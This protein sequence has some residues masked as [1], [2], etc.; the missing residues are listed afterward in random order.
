MVTLINISMKFYKGVVV[1]I[2]DDTKTGIIKCRVNGLYNS[3][4]IGSIPDDK[5]PKLYPL[6]SPNLNNFDTPKVGEEVYVVLDRDDKHAGFWIG[7]YSLSDE[8][9]TKIR[10]DYEGFKSI[11]FDEEE[12]LRCFFSRKEGLVLE[13]D[14]ARIIIK[15]NEAKVE[16]PDRKLHILDGMISLGQLKKSNEPAVLGDKNLDALNEICDRMDAMI[17]KLIEYG[18]TQTSV[19]S[20]VGILAFLAPALTKLASDMGAIK[21]QVAQT[22]T[23]TN[24]KTKSTKTSLD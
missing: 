3:N 19:V 10:D 23:V 17:D 6:Y 9:K 14:K 13:L 5:L 4:S 24:P 15:D 7:K 20:S 2:E 12:K 22:K 8:F 1:S 16:T 21:T 18:T 11:K